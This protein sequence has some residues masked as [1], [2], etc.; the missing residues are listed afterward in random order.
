MEGENS[1]LKGAIKNVIG[2]KK[3]EWL[4]EIESYFGDRGTLEMDAL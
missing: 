1:R 2:A 3:G 4:G